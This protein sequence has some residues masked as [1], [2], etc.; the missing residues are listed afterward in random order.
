MTQ[1]FL[2]AAVG[3]QS[4]PDPGNW[5]PVNTVECLGNGGKGGTGSVAG[6][7]GGGGG[8]SY[9]IG[10]NITPTFPA[11]YTVPLGTTSGSNCNFNTA[12]AG[13][14][15]TPGTVSASGGI[16]GPGP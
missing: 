12:T 2:L 13:T 5:N 3:L 6:G 4:F 7:G 16:A 11:P 10:N 14:S 8:G 1:V 15:T 9:A